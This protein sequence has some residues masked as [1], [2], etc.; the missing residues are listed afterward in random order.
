MQDRIQRAEGALLSYLG[1]YGLAATV[2]GGFEVT[3]EDDQ[4][5]LT[6]LDLPGAEQLPLPDPDP[7]WGSVAQG[8]DV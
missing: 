2:I 3:L 1:L 5:N 7:D 4:L 6:H 8:G